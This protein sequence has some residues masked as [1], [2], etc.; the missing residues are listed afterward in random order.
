MEDRAAADQ[1]AGHL[2]GLVRRRARST[3][4]APASA[5][6]SPSSSSP[7]ARSVPVERLTESVWGDRPPADPAGA[8]QAYVSHLRRRLAAGQR[9]PDRARRSSSARAAGTPSGCRP[10]RSTPGG[11]SGCC[12]RAGDDDRPRAAAGLLAEALALWRGPPLAE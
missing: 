2:H 8:L 1:P 6:S 10:T 5:P 12:D 11:S 4:A 7:G 3:S 9:R